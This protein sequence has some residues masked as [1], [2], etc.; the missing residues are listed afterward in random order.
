MARCPRPGRAPTT[1][2]AHAGGPR[3]ALDRR[4]FLGRGA[5]LA[6]GV[7]LASLL[8][9]CGGDGDGMRGEMP[10]WMMS[11]G[12]MM[13]SAMREHMRV[14]HQLLRRHDEITRE[15]DDVATGIR[16]RT[17][18]SDPQLAELLRTHV[19]QMKGRVESGNAIRRMDPVFREIFEHHAAVE[20]EVKPLPE[21][22]LVVETS[23]DPQ[24]EL[25]IRQHAHRAV[26]EFVREGMVR[27]RR[28][29]PLPRGYRS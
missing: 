7:P 29:T 3:A 19:Q 22:V 13:D 14:I 15:V 27:A 25:L 2:P 12:G 11:G 24:V 18:S 6:A 21:G 28:P 23:G 17:T 20:M 10:S 8:G 5:A 26:S 4:T 1:R 9:A 16:S